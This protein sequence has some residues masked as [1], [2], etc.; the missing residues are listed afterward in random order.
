MTK[1]PSQTPSLQTVDIKLL[2]IF[3][4]VVRNNGFAAAQAELNIASSS[5]S[6]SMTR[7][8]SRLDIKLCERGRGGFYLTEDGRRV[9]EEV[10][11]LLRSLENFRVQIGEIKGE[12]SGTLHIGIVDAIAM[13]DDWNVPNAIEAFCQEAPAVV[14]RV[15]TDTTQGIVSGLMSELYDVAIVPIYR[16]IPD[17]ELVPIKP[18]SIQRLYC[19]S[20]HALFD[21]ADASIEMEGLESLPFVSLTHMKGWSNP[22]DLAF[23]EVASTSF[24]EGVAVM[25]LSNCFI[26]Y[27]PEHFAAPWVDAGKMRSI[28]PERFTYTSQCCFAAKRSRT[29]RLAGAFMKCA[30]STARRVDDDD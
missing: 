26:G 20:G 7:L 3:D 17:L 22:G 13:A 27:L 14:L 6:E 21:V 12:L 15:E 28:L 5:I 18:E 19:G 30:A 9:L 2:R 23:N 25:I 1:N 8:E 16:D 10:N 11:R 29:S 24:M 4:S